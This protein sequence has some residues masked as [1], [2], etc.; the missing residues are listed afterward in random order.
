MSLYIEFFEMALKHPRER[1]L[2]VTDQPPRRSS[3][4]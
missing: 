1:F 4:V 2:V 3:A